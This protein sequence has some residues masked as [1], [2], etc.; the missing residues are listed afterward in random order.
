M[1]I[2][3][4]GR[5]NAGCISAMH[6]GYFRKFLNTKV[7]I[8]LI[9]D[10]KIKPVPTGQGTTL[11]F[12]DWL[13]KNFGSNYVNKFSVTQKTGIMY[14]NWSKKNKKIF[15][16]FPLGRYGIH[17]N[18]EDFQNF[19]CKNLKID[20]KERDE[21]IKDYNTL[22]ADYIIDCRGTPK[23]LTNYHTLTNPLN[24][25]LLA[26]LPKK[27]NDV[28]WT[29]T[30]ATPDGWCFYIPLPKKT[31]IGY[32]FNN[33]ITSVKKAKYNFKKLF[34]VEKINHVFPF[35]QYV[36]KEPIIDNRVL[37]NGNKL[38]FLEPLEATA[39]G[40]YIKINQFYYNYIFNNQDKK[41]TEFHI[42]S[43][44]KKIEQFIL[45]HYSNGSI[46]DNN[47]WK[48]A[49]NLWDNTETLM[50]DKELKIIKGMSPLDFERSLSED[51]EFAQWPSFSIKLWQDKIA[52]K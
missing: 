25:A 45:Y 19:V 38:F 33:K 35:K 20:F 9:Y 21:N 42:H 37:L 32:L 11:E 40:S 30:T 51:K 15:H 50:L 28:L 6:F 17:F 8:E 52:F 1:K 14:E 23:N 2:I 18:P 48:K 3:I 26:D 10:S 16:G 34:G 46:Y 5:G 44:V 13:F 43:W 41:D 24:C 29:K 36:A 39:M 31:S 4:L 22:D 7:E 27:E 12:P 49:K 47:F